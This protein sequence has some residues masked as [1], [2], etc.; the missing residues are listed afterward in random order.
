MVCS[1]ASNSATESLRH[2][3]QIGIARL[4]AGLR[5]HRMHLTAMMGLM[6]EEVRDQLPA[7]LGEPLR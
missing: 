6:V 5:Q 3:H 7:R 1:S 4:A 2:E